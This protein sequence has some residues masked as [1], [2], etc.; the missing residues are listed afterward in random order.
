MKFSEYEG[1]IYSIFCSLSNGYH[2]ICAIDTCSYDSGGPLLFS[3]A[4]N[5]LYQIGITSYGVSCATS[6]PSVSTRVT[7]YLDWITSE[8]RYARFCVPWIFLF[9]SEFNSFC[10]NWTSLT[11]RIYDQKWDVLLLFLFLIKLFGNSF[12]FSFAIGA[13]FRETSKKVFFSTA[14][15]TSVP[16]ILVFFSLPSGFLSLLFWEFSWR[17]AINTIKE[18]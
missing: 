17:N 1:E 9:L 3:D 4:N 2:L 15:R 18:K 10:V 8:A 5:L 6:M 11:L 7:A 14:T 12:N 13:Q 16:R